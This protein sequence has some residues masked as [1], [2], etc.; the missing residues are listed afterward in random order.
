MARD[1]STGDESHAFVLG[2][3]VVVEQAGSDHAYLLALGMF[4]ERLDPV[5]VDRLHIVVEQE[6]EVPACRGGANVDEA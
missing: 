4:Q 5:H 2:C 6:Q 3:A 1:A